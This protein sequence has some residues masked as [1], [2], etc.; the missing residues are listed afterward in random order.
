MSPLL[1][2]YDFLDIVAKKQIEGGDIVLFKAKNP[3]EEEWIVHRIT[4]IKDK[5]VYT[6]GD[7]NPTI[8][9]ESL[10]Y[11][12]IAGI[13][14]ARWRNGK[15]LTIYRGK[16]GII[17]YRLYIIYFRVRKILR[18]GT[19]KLVLP[20]Q[21]KSAMRKILPKPKEVCFSREYGHA[22]T[23][24]LGSVHIGTY[25]ERNRCWQIRFP[26]RLIY[27]YRVQ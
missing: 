14:T 11:D 12:E 18:A 13:V 2:D 4:I 16:K 10:Q 27:D 1:V 9:D 22:K 7:N 26:Y 19:G 3:T 20:G 6:K 21:L 5:R 25:S 8:D 24:Y 17:Q 15:K 23:L